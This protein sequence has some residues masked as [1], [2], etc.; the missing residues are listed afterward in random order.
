M[1]AKGSF[2]V[3]KGLRFVHHLPYTST[4]FPIETEDLEIGVDD[5]EEI[6]RGKQ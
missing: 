4:L 1:L 3:V 2:G 5:N 6:R